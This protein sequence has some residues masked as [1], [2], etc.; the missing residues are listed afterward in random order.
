MPFVV[1][2]CVMYRT[3]SNG[4]QPCTIAEVA[5]MT[6]DEVREYGQIYKIR[7]GDWRIESVG[8]IDLRRATGIEAM[9]QAV[10]G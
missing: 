4:W 6:R 2:D 7:I 1:G 5:V 3:I 8:E 10:Y 9:R